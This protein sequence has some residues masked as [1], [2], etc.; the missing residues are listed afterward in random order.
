MRPMSGGGAQ[1]ARAEQLYA[2]SSA[3][4]WYVCRHC[5]FVVFPR[6]WFMNLLKPDALHSRGM[7]RGEKWSA[8]KA[9]TTYS[10]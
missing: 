5:R 2:M 7:L 1:K 10:L 9:V 6:V 4:H 8:N 3:S